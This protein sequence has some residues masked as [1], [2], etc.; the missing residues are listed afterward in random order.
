MTWSCDNLPKLGELTRNRIFSMTCQMPFD[1]FLGISLGL[2]LE[3]K[4]VLKSIVKNAD[5]LQC[6]TFKSQKDTHVPKLFSS[7]CQM[8]SPVKC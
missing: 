4:T 7:L 3:F 5:T 6:F 2:L 8:L 1:L